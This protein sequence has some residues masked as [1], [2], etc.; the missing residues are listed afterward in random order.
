MNWTLEVV[1]VPVSD[2][3]RAK[4]FYADQLGFKV[5]HDTTV[6]DDVRVTHTNF[7]PIA[8]AAS[9][10]SCGVGGFSTPASQGM[11]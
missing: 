4:A 1:V 5:D 10:V 8:A 11:P 7:Y 3:N 2:L 9:A 6:S